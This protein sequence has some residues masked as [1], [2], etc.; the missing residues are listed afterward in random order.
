MND[1]SDPQMGELGGGWGDGRRHE[2]EVVDTTI[3]ARLV[4]PL[5]HLAEGLVQLLTLTLYRPGWPL[6]FSLHHMRVV[7]KETF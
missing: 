5:I 6:S 2:I 7:R 1:L 3:P 4:V